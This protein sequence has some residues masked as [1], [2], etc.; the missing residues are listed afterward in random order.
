[1]SKRLSIKF[2]K[3]DAWIGVYW[4]NLHVWF[5]ILP[6][7]PIEFLRESICLYCNERIKGEFGNVGLHDK[8]KNKRYSEHTD[9]LVTC[10]EAQSI[11][12]TVDEE[13]S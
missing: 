5:C 2:K 12:D 6:F 13:C 8:I 10:R 11:N 1:M 3:Q 9:E 4:D 7:F